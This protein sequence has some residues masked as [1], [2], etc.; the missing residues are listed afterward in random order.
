MI[1]A[2]TWVGQYLRGSILTAFHWNY[3]EVVMPEDF[4]II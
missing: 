4:G 1:S 2:L 3:F